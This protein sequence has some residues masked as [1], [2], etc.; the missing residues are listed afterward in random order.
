M[1]WND[2]AKVLDWRGLP[3]GADNAVGPPT[4]TPQ[5]QPLPLEALPETALEEDH[6]SWALGLAEHA[7]AMQPRAP[8]PGGA[9][10][11]P[12]RS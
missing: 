6:A 10:G 5:H 7:R 1:R 3:S 2:G 4:E 8:D 12:R 9:A 11:R